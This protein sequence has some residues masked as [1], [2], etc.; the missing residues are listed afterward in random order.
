MPTP[1]EV[2]LANEALNKAGEM[3]M[4]TAWEQLEYTRDCVAQA[5]HSYG[6]QRAAEAVA[7]C[8]KAVEGAG[9]DD[10]QWETAYEEGNVNDSVNRMKSVIV[11]A[12]R[13]VAAKYGGGEGV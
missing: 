3:K 6:N 5:L 9:F 7:E 8:V 2:K 12:V 11:G 13:L 10:D 1:N 4:A